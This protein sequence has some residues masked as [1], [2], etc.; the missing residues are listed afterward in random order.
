MTVCRFPGCECQT[1]GRDA[2]FCTDH[3]FACPP[4]EAGFLIR[5]SIAA[6]RSESPA[7]REHLKEQFHGYVCQ[8]VRK[9]QER[10]KQEA[11]SVA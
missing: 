9:I 7:E 2:V 5:M 3:H 10:Q 4:Q 1:N 6:R 8:A 11:S